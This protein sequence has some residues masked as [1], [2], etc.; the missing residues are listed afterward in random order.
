[1]AAVVVYTAGL[2]GVSPVLLI[3]QFLPALAAG[4][5]VTFSLAAR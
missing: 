3:R 2:V 4:A 1:M 5:A